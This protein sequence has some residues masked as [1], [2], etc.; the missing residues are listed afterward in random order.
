MLPMH[1]VPSG[2]P[3]SVRGFGGLRGAPPTLPLPPAP[4]EPPDAA[5]VPPEFALPATAVAPLEFW[6]PTAPAPPEPGPSVAAPSLLHADRRKEATQSPLNEIEES[7][8]IAASLRTLTIT[9]GAPM[10]RILSASR[11]ATKI[12]DCADSMNMPQAALKRIAIRTRWG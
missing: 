12:P 9:K 7:F 2:G 1:F 4:D 5:G 6:P 8:N 11:V 3:M 10:S